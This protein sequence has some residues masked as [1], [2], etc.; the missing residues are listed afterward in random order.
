[1]SPRP[2]DGLLRFPI[3]AAMVILVINDHWGKAVAPG[4]ATGKLS[5]FAGMLFFPLLLQALW[6]LGCAGIG[7]YT[8]PSRR[9]LVVA[10]ISTAVV[11]AAINLW[12]LAGEAYRWG[13]G[14]LQ[15]PALALYTGDRP[16]IRPVH[17]T[18]DPGDV[19]ALPM[20]GLAV[21]IGWNRQPA[22]VA[23]S[24]SS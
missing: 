8:G 15:W 24:S 10:A 17:L 6:E 3:L 13:L 22:A 1:M 18:M 12:P 7:R 5:D 2:G 20:C 16:A 14:A 21:L 4:W 19:I 11:F 23:V 9:V